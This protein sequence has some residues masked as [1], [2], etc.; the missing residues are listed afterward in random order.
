MLT[1]SVQQLL[2]CEYLPILIQPFKYQ[3]RASR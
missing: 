2:W 3:K 1:Y